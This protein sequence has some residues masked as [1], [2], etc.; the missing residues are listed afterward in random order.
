[1]EKAIKKMDSAIE[2]ASTIPQK[3]KKQFDTK[4][5]KEV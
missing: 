1:M 3:L 4:E 2:K 5:A